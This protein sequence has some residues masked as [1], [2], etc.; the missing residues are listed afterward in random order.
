MQK[1]RFG[2]FRAFCAVFAA[3]L[4]PLCNACRI[5]RTANDVITDAGQ[6]L[7][8]SAANEY[9]A[10]LLQIVTFAGN[11]YRTFLLVGQSDSRNLSH[12]R[13]R[14]LGG[15]GRNR[16]AYASLLRALIQNRAFGLVRFALSSLLD[17]LVDRGH[18]VT[19][20]YY[21]G[22]FSTDRKAIQRRRIHMPDGTFQAAFLRFCA[23][24]QRPFPRTKVILA[25][26]VAFVK[27]LK[28][29]F[30]NNLYSM[31]I[32]WKNLLRIFSESIDKRRKKRY[33]IS[34]K[35]LI[36]ELYS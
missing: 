4:F 9:G 21:F 18:C 5:E 6:I 10:V 14:L 22:I 17:E 32:F 28:V 7:N 26:N 20:L 31:P 24:K 30:P 8:S 12:S 11:V 19:S 1:S 34:G 23:Q 3:G 35:R 29:F 15:S 36:K 13:V 25:N 27:R 2:L 16:K 33:D